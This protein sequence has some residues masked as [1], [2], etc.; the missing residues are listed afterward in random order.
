M[1]LKLECTYKRWEAKNSYQAELRTYTNVPNKLT[2]DDLMRTPLTRAMKKREYDTFMKAML[3]NTIDSEDR[4]IQYINQ[5]YKS[6]E[7][8]H[9]TKSESIENSLTTVLSVVAIGA[10]L[11]VISGGLFG[12]AVPGYIA[13]AGQ[14]AGGMLT[15]KDIGYLITGK[16]INGNPLS[17]ADKEAL[18]GSF[19]LDATMVGVNFFHK[20]KLEYT[21]KVNKMDGIEEVS[22]ADLLKNSGLDKVKVDEIVSIPKGSRPDPSTYLSKEYMDIHLSQFDDGLSVIQTEWAYRR[23][24]ET[25]GFVGVPDDNTLFV[26]PKKYC[27]EVLFKA[28]GDISI[29]EKELGFPKGYFRDGGG[30]VRIDVDDI[31]GLNIRLPSGN[32][33]GAN[34][35]W[36]PGGYTSG[37]VP[38]AIT[39]IIPLDKTTISRVNLE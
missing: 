3:G 39:D 24:S 14:V 8:D 33:T 37:K 36:I 34:S 22:K 4:Y 11:T 30:L 18:M 23:Y 7:F 2:F 15:A 29:I 21:N 31:M 26:L 9:T 20:L 6:A 13:T 25:N 10:G 12:F 1:I 27:D 32:E 35:L 19:I 17:D 28:N 16:D 38:E 5:L